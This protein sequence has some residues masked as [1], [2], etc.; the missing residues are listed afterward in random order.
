M[1]LKIKIEIQLAILKKTSINSEYKPVG[2]E[3][4]L[5]KYLEKKNN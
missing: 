2:Y 1:F 3:I 4:S 5:S